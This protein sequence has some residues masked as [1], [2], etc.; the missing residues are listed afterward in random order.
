LH[1]TECFEIR[2]DAFALRRQCINPLSVGTKG[3]IHLLLVEVEH[4]ACASVRVQ[5]FPRLSKN[6]NKRKKERNEKNRKE[7]REEKGEEDDEEEVEEEKKKNKKK[8]KESPATNLPESAVKSSSIE[9][10]RFSCLA[11][12]SADSGSTARSEK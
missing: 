11:I 2:R 10:S 5:S 8:E 9:S 6:E 4:F 1:P 12:A 3:C 7:Q